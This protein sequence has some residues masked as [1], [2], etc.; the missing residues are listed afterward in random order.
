MSIIS[1]YLMKLLPCKHTGNYREL[2]S[3]DAV[4]CDCNKK[5][6]FIGV[7]REQARGT[8]RKE[9]GQQRWT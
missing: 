1:K 8:N 6:G 9:V 5:I 7:V 4:C 3:C 2:M